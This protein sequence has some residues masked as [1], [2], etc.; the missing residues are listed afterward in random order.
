MEIDII[1]S[2]RMEKFEGKGGWTYVV[3]PESKEFFGTSGAVKVKGLVDGK[4][5][6]GTFMP[7]GGGRQM[8]PINM[9]IRRLIGKDAG[10]VVEV[11]LLE[12]IE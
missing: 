7:M 12:R 10:E 11:R 9:Q 1:F 3:W 2:A 6:A 8:L 5:F 4:P